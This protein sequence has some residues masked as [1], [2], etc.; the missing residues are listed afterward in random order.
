MRRFYATELLNKEE[1]FLVYSQQAKKLLILPLYFLNFNQLC[2]L[3]PQNIKH[4]GS[5]ICDPRRR[6]T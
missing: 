3:V 6:R 5:I 1:E 2:I 4:Y